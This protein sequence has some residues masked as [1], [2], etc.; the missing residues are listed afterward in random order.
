MMIFRHI[1]HVCSTY[2]L[3]TDDLEILP[4]VSKL[5]GAWRPRDRSVEGRI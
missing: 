4:E 3:F 1:V 2:N 5:S